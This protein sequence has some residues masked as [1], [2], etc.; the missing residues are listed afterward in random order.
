MR[1]D[2]PIVCVLHALVQGAYT[3]GDAPMSGLQSSMQ[4]QQEQFQRL[5][6]HL[7]PAPPPPSSGKRKQSTIQFAN[8]EAQKYYVDGT[9][10]PDGW[11]S[12]LSRQS[13]C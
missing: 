13:I 8:P 11:L 10:I 7:G 12:A 3:I 6:D 4:I 9:T 5:S 2:L 1:V